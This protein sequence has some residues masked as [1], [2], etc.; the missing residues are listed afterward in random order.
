MSTIRDDLNSFNQFAAARLAAP[1]SLA[2]IDE[3]FSE[4]YD[5]RDREQ[6][7]QAIRQ[8]LA[9]VAAGRYQPAEQAMDAIRQEF[10]LGDK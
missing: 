5:F 8:G 4:W 3:L 9:D 6:I 10:G 7:N 2:S 1:D